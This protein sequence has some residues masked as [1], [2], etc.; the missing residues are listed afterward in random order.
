VNGILD[1]W[2]DWNG[3]G[4]VDDEECRRAVTVL[5]RDGLRQGYR[6]F[7]EF[8]HTHADLDMSEAITIPEADIVVEAAFGPN[9]LPRPVEGPVDER[10][11]I[12]MD[13]WIIPI[14]IEAFRI[15]LTRSV[16]SI[17]GL[18]LINPAT[19][20]D[21]EFLVI[22]AD[23]NED[24]DLNEQELRDVG[25]VLLRLLSSTELV[26]N[27]IEIRFDTNRDFRISDDER[28]SAAAVILRSLPQHAREQLVS[29]AEHPERIVGQPANSDIGREMDVDPE[30]GIVED[31]EVFGYLENRFVDLAMTWLA[32]AGDTGV[33]MIE[34]PPP[35][36][37]ADA[38]FTSDAGTRTANPPNDGQD[39][40]GDDSAG[41]DTTQTETRPNTV[42]K[43]T[44][45]ATNARQTNP[46]DQ[47]GDELSIA[48]S[49]NPVYPVL[50]KYYDTSP[51]GTAVI[52]NT[53]DHDLTGL[54][55]TLSVTNYT[56]RDRVFQEIESLGT[57]ESVSVDLTL[58]LNTSVL[59]VTEGDRVDA[60]VNVEYQG[61]AGQT[62]ESA[63]ETLIF[64]DRNAI[65][66]DDTR[67][68][69]AFVTERDEEIRG[70]A[71][72]AIA[73]TRDERNEAVDDAFQD[74]M[75]LFT[76]MA[77]SE[78]M[79]FLDPSSSYANASSSGTTIDYV[80]FPRETFVYY[81]GDCDDLSVCYNAL[82]ESVGRKTAFITVPGHIMPAFALGLSPSEARSA[83]LDPTD[84][85][86]DSNDT[87]WVPVEITA[88]EESF[89]EA[90]QDAAATYR[91]YSGS[92]QAEII[93]TE[94]AWQ[95]YESVQSVSNDE[96]ELPDSD[97]VESAFASALSEFVN[98]QIATRELQL[99]AD[100]EDHPG[101]RRLLNRLGVLYA[102]YGLWDKARSQFET[103]VASENYIPALVNL[104]HIDFLDGE[105]SDASDY[106]ER[107][108]DIK[109]DHTGAL[110]AEARA[111]HELE[112]YGNVRTY[113]EQL[114]S[115][116]PRLAADF[117]YLDL[118]SSNEA[119]R[120]QA[121]SA[122]R[123][124][125]IWETEDEEE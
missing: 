38:D 105:Y 1:D 10:L 52:T 33:Q 13:G 17:P 6:F 107:V 77:E 50:R 69:A 101:D 92:G 75:I 31:H 116:S 29:V 86:F 40:T 30:N 3:N 25:I 27:P 5:Y 2:F 124:R 73:G 28:R 74:A 123:D 117:A 49:L 111:Q 113:Y 34:L 36:E 57:G 89:Y 67:R 121:A 71:R 47:A 78:L 20:G 19:P 87:V 84:L 114:R 8:A 68:V 93:P 43:T 9:A 58:L 83:F 70:F 14:E 95:L 81:G 51:I 44:T 41:K 88:L 97:A 118:S 60:S 61:A 99:K 63:T 122:V 65:R 46:V 100:L 4:T 21:G 104:G 11:D 54:E 32:E 22:W 96:I 94:D 106:Y 110:L 55:V 16:A 18:P 98:T 7:P 72:R 66:W 37:V 35:E 26:T 80:Q 115:L 112:N 120:A 48:V 108:L 56:D 91:R 62:E 85:V 39:A 82:L 64:Y 90:W 109:P 23:A 102:Q 12:D 59:N 15:S 45:V 119:S 79:Y 125:V 76:A 24:G 53:S 103:I 42:V